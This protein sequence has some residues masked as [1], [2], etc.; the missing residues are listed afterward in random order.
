MTSGREVRPASAALSVL[1]NV[2]NISGRWESPFQYLAFP[3]AKPA[4]VHFVHLVGAGACLLTDDSDARSFIP[5]FDCA[6]TSSL[7]AMSAEVCDLGHH[8]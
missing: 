6:G 1:S 7:S 4:C 5:Q 8:H 3:V 2:S